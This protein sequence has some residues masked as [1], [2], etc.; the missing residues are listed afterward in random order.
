VD[1]QTARATLDEALALW[2]G[3]PLADVDHLEIASTEVPRLE[4]LKVVAEEALM[5]AELAVGHHGEAV[6]D[7]RDS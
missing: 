3:Q 4:E 6:A 2:R 1:A 5:S 7:C